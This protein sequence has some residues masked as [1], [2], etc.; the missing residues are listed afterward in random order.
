[1]IEQGLRFASPPAYVL[2]TSMAFRYKVVGWTL[3]LQLF[4]LFLRQ[5]RGL[6][7]G[8]DIDTQ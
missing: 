2:V 7:N 4:D 3:Q 8:F 5:T 1:M 6:H